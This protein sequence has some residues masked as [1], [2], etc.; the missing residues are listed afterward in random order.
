M[1]VYMDNMHSG[2]YASVDIALEHLMDSA[3]GSHE[4]GSMVESGTA[5]LRVGGMSSRCRALEAHVE[6]LAHPWG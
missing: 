5:A 1:C 2:R 3:G 4:Q 6:G